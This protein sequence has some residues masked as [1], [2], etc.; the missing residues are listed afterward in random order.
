MENS[1]RNLSCRNS[2]EPSCRTAAESECRQIQAGAAS[3][4][5]GDPL[6]SSFPAAISTKRQDRRRTG[7][8]AQRRSNLHLTND[9]E[10]SK[11]AISTKETEE[12]QMRRAAHGAVKRRSISTTH[13]MR[14]AAVPRD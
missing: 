4:L 7:S 5:C 13:D 14:Q 1:E 2:A 3:I 12:M 6:F 10:N 8:R 11:I 9:C